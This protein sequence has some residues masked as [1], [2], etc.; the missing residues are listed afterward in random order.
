[1]GPEPKRDPGLQP[2][3]TRL[4]WRRTALAGTAVALLVLR[5]AIVRG[6]P[7]ILVVGVALW[8]AMLVIG[9][10]R[11]AALTPERTPYQH[12]AIGRALP[13]ITMALIGY[14][15]LGAVLILS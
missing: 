7:V 4:A 6:A 10:R 2:E 15:V 8:L 3:R 11:M 5:F 9:H 14:A 1:M 13:A 12:T